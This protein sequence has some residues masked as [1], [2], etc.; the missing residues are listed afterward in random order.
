MTAQ[1]SQIFYLLESNKAL[2]KLLKSASDDVNF[3][4]L[5]KSKMSETQQD[6]HLIK[7]KQSLN[8]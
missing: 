7:I 1:E 4:I 8:I 5:H 6:I 2:R 3:L